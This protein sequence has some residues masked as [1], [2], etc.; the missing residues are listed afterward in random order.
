MAAFE[1][2]LAQ[3]SGQ[4]AAFLSSP[5]HHPS[6][7]DSALPSSGYWERIRRLCD[8]HGVVLILDD[9]RAGFRLDSGGSNEHFGFTPDL[10]CF[11]KAIANGYPLAA[12]VGGES[13]QRDAARVRTT[14]SYC[15]K[16]C[17]WPPLWRA[18]ESYDA[19][20]LPRS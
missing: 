6:L 19:W 16:R 3:H 12:L 15:S 1:R 10:I 7:Q 5:Y 20:K 13:L 4:V 8:K 9:V 2:V 17:P 11:C 14:G 18:S